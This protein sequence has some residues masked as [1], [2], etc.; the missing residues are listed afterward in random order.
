MAK[1]V[2]ANALARAVV[3]VLRLALGYD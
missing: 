3:K 1:K 2:R